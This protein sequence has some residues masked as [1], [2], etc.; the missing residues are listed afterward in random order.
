[1]GAPNPTPSS[2]PGT[3]HGPRPWNLRRKALI[4]AAAASVPLIVALSGAVWFLSSVKAQ[5]A[6]VGPGE[7]EAERWAARLAVQA[8]QCRHFEQSYIL[9]LRERE[10]RAHDRA[11]WAEAWEGLTQALDQMAS[12]VE[13]A[14]ARAKITGWRN[15]AVQYRVRMLD[16]IQRVDEGELTD[17]LAASQMLAPFEPAMRELVDQGVGQG[18]GQGVGQA[19]GQAVAPGEPGTPDPT[20]RREEL[21]RRIGLGMIML[22]VLGLGTV[23]LLT[24]LGLLLAHRLLG[25]V[26]VL[27]EGVRRIAEGALDTRVDIRSGD[28]IEALGEQ[29]NRMA[30]SLSAH[31]Q[32]LDKSTR[33]AEAS[34]RAKAEFLATMSHEI[35]TPLTGVIG[36]SDLLLGTRLTSEQR[37][38]VET[39][40]TSAEALLSL[41]NDILDFSKFESG[42]IEL[43]EV[44]FDL[45]ALAEDVIQILGSRAREKHLDLLL[46][47][48]Q[49][50]PRFFVGDPGR[51]R[52]I[53]LNLVGNALKFTEL[54]HVLLAVSHGGM[55]GE[56]VRVELGVED[57]GIGIPEESLPVIFDRFTRVNSIESRRAGGTGLGLAISRQ[58]VELMGGKISVSSEL[59]K[60]STFTF[61]L[62]LTPDRNPSIEALP[63]A[64]LA[65]ARIAIIDDSAVNRRVLVELLQ[66]WNARVSAFPNAYAA[67]AGL[68]DAQAKGE[69]FD[70]AVIDSSMPDMDGAE[71]GAE[72][73]ADPMLA[74]LSMVLLTSNPRHGDARRYQ[75]LGFVGYLTKPAKRNVL[76]ETLRT[77]LG[78]KR[79][80]VPVPLVTRHRVAESQAIRR[81]TTP[82]AVAHMLPELESQAVPEP[83][84]EPMPQPMLAREVSDAVARAVTGTTRVLL[85]DDTQV[86]RRLASKM[87][88]KLGVAVD[89]AANG[90]E[91]VAKA[92]TQH[93]ALILMDCQ[94]PEMDGYEATQRIREYEG[95]QRH[96]P[97]VAMTASAM[98]EDRKRCLDA[99]MDDYISKPVRQDTLRSAV[100]KWLVRSE[101]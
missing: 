44:A 41:I 95:E 86:N 98:P 25:R 43:D 18:I 16:V 73:Q 27:D 67:L 89:V 57:T 76:L 78:S 40:N 48:D 10:A 66:G 83:V 77:V 2:A 13:D 90:L 92:E 38:F 84:P 20:A 26:A 94:M 46:R 85:V 74:D 49:G 33:D 28:E 9:H 23:A 79:A 64:N 29:F 82:G 91:A 35:R 5:V 42:N 22:A 101:S 63:S 80:G 87:L 50:L 11:R 99:G 24:L 58:I 88:E 47:Y 55:A 51:I 62:P 69:P 34:A 36:M 14:E 32:A 1:M 37:E 70:I 39:L 54:G 60:G 81:I 72:M 45:Q 21:T 61:V 3:A 52:Q 56:R 97:I 96:T 30:E 31:R 65:G 93:Y 6:W 68:R 75:D 4:L 8:L 59:G 7:A 19:A 15:Q 53:L 12:R 17:P 100:S 71:L